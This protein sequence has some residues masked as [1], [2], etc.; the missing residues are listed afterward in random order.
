MWYTSALTG[1]SSWDTERTPVRYALLS[2]VLAILARDRSS[3][4]CAIATQRHALL[5]YFEAVV[6]ARKAVLSVLGVVFAAG[7]YNAFCLDSVATDT[8]SI[9]VLGVVVSLYFFRLVIDYAYLHV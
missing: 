2:C 1:F 7:L 9:L 5:D 3:L 8:L 4:S 6:I